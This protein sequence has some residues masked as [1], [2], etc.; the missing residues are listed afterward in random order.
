MLV[1]ARRCHQCG[2]FKATPS[3]TAYVYCDYCAAFFD[4]DFHLAMTRDGLW[5]EA[6]ETGINSAFEEPLKQARLADDR[7]Q[8]AKLV[9]DRER[10]FIRAAPGAYSPRIGD[11]AYLESYIERWVVPWYLARM[12]DDRWRNAWDACRRVDR[13]PEG[14]RDRDAVQ[15]L[16]GAH[17]KLWTVETRLC[18]AAFSAHPDS[19]NADTYGRMNLGAFVASVSRWL[20]SESREWL[21]AIA[22]LKPTWIEIPENRSATRS[23]GHCGASMIVFEGARRRVCEWC[24]YTVE[25]N[26]G[27]QCRSC[28]APLTV[29][30]GAKAFPCPHCGL[31]F[32]IVL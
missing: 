16:L 23:C 14:Y 26:G 3:K 17:R 21:I 19:L 2:A 32:E 27:I 25:V 11:P 30:A 20:D 1:R 12:F 5:I 29:P 8:Y 24:G 9:R 18:G 4:W 15:E 13:G 22:G 31:R 28:G 6:V 7:N 10:L